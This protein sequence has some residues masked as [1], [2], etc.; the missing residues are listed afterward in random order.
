ML[1]F[2]TDLT[3][4]TMTF[5][6]EPSDPVEKLKQLIMERRGVPVDQQRLIHGPKQ[7]EDGKLFSD[8]DIHEESTIHF[9]VRLP[10]GV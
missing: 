1:I 8:Y 4:K 10:G 2:V 7:L 9:V 5:Q 3:G 6:V